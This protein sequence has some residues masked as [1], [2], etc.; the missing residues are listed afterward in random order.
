MTGGLQEHGLGFKGGLSFFIFRVST[1][2]LQRPHYLARVI[3]MQMSQHGNPLQ[4]PSVIS[5]CEAPVDIIQE[6]REAI[7]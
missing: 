4:Q 6:K 2:E 1:F 5:L 3:D 7:M